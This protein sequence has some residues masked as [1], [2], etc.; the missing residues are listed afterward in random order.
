MKKFLE[1][2]G[3]FALI[4]STVYGIFLLFVAVLWALLCFTAWRV[5]GFPP[6]ELLRFVGGIVFIYASCATISMAGD[7]S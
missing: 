4:L 1:H 5:L 3:L 7:E 2:L 6:S